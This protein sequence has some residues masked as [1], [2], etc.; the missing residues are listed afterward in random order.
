MIEVWSPILDQQSHFWPKVHL[1]NQKSHV[2]PNIPFL[3]KSPPS[4]TKKNIFYQKALVLPKIW[5]LT[6][7]QFF[8]QKPI[9]L[10]K[11]KCLPNNAIFDQMKGLW[12]LNFNQKCYIIKFLSLCKVYA[13]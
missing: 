2:S 3:T 6:K 8:E 5:F 10:P 13:L 12:V 7:S 1:C 11:N 9:F 4:I